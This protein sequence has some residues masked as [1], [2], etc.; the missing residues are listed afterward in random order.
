MLVEEGDDFFRMPSEAIVTVLEAP[1]RILPLDR[2]TGDSTLPAQPKTRSRPAMGK[3][4]TEAY[5]VAHAVGG[6]A[7]RFKKLSL[8]V[9]H[10][11]SPGR[12]AVRVR[13]PL[14]ALSA[15]AS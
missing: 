5:T 15:P 6:K 8:A 14:P 4:Y 1:G 2:V 10:L 3:T 12:E 13:I 11:K 9:K 7:Q